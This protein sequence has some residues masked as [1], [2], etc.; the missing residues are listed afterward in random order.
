MWL[1]HVSECWCDHRGG[2]RQLPQGSPVQGRE[3]GFHCKFNRKPRKVVWFLK[4]SAYLVRFKFIKSCKNNTINL[5]S[6]SSVVNI[7]PHLLYPLF[8]MY[9]F[10]RSISFV[11]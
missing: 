11:Y 4:K 9:I 10:F 7:L 6:N 3:F 1:E 8:S 2:G 5:Y